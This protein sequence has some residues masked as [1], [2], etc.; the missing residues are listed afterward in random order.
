MIFSRSSCQIRPV[1]FATDGLFSVECHYPK[2]INETIS[3]AEAASARA[4][5]ILSQE[6]LQVGGVI[7]VVEGER[8]AA[9]LTCVRVLPL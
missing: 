6:A 4:A 1:D 3:Q 8:C 2:S 5:T 7:A 9:C